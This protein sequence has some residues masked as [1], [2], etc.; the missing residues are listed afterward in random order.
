MPQILKKMRRHLLVASVV[1]GVAAAAAA[2]A[3]FAVLG[4]E[5]L[6]TLSEAIVHASYPAHN[7]GDSHGGLHSPDVSGSLRTTDDVVI[8]YHPVEESHPPTK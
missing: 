4:I 7:P 5:A 1:T 6:D 3:V 2:V 8:I